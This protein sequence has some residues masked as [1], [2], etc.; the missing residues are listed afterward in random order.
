MNDLT[1]EFFSLFENEPVIWNPRIPDHKNR[2]K[3]AD[4][5]TNIQRQSSVECSVAELKKQKR[6][7]DGNVSPVIKQS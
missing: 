4:S 6:I 3:V 7:P 2:N 5:W 1:L